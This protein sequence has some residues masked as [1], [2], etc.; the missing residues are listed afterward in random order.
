MVRLCFV[1]LGNICRS[2]TAEG[3]M[4]H[5][6]RLEG[7]ERAL[8][9]DS[10][11][12]AAYHVGERPDRRTIA[13]AKLHGVEL[14]SRA[15]QFQRD[16]FARFDLVLAMDT[17]NRDDLLRLAPDDASRAKVLL[18]RDFEPD[19]GPDASVPDPYYGDQ[20]GFEEV[21]AICQRACTGLLAHV[22][23]E[24]EL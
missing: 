18:L 23:R 11:G 1:C 14:P 21:F 17:N 3:V 5:H 9:V 16:D 19:A 15:R 24:Y 2:P 12:T 22:R 7:L 4:A 20:A 13:T 10:A 6:V 8:T